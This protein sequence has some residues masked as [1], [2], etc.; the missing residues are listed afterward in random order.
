MYVKAPKGIKHTVLNIINMDIP[1]TNMKHTT[2]TWVSD[3]VQHFT[4][5]MIMFVYL[6]GLVFLCNVQ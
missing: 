3:S 5:I 1:V 2:G 4:L 6:L